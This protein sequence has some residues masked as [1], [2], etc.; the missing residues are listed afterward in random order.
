MGCWWNSS[1]TVATVADGAR[2]PNWAWWAAL[3]WAGTLFALSA[4][5]GDGGAFDFAWRFAGDDKLVHAAL[6]AVLGAILRAASGRTGWAIGLGSAYGVTDEI[7]QA[8]V[9]GRHADP[10]DWLADTAGAALGALLVASFARR[11]ER[12]TVE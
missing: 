1:N 8:F 9:P 2:R 7:H 10:L 3:A 11:A 12:R 4:S 6:Y 5:S